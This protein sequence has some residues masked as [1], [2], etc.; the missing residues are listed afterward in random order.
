MTVTLLHHER[1]A[2]T[3]DHRILE[4]QPKTLRKCLGA[5]MNESM[6]T[7][8]MSKLLNRYWKIEG[9]L[10]LFTLVKTSKLHLIKVLKEASRYEINKAENKFDYYISY[11]S[12]INLVSML[13]IFHITS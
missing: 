7:S 3:A 1:L 4:I 12:S 5:D 6:K 2:Q 10:Y 11:V 8:Q 13:S 9:H